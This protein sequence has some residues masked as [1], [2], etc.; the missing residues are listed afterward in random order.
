MAGQPGIDATLDLNGIGSVQASQIDSSFSNVGN[1]IDSSLEAQYSSSIADIGI[2]SADIPSSYS[3][4]TK[5]VD[6]TT[7]TEAT[8]ESSFQATAST[9]EVNREVSTFIEPENAYILSIIAEL[10]INDDMAEEMRLEMIMNLLANNFSYEADSAGEAWNTV[11]NTLATRSGDCED[12]SN[13]AASLLVAAGFPAEDVNV[14]VNIS[15]NVGEQGHVVVG[16]MINDQEV[17]LDF[18]QMINAADGN[19]I[20]VNES[21]YSNNQLN[22]QQYDFSY[23]VNGVEKLSAS[24]SN[25]IVMEDVNNAESFYTA[26]TTILGAARAELINK[27]NSL[28]PA[29]ASPGEIFILLQ[30]AQ[31]YLDATTEGANSTGARAELISS[32]NNLNPETA[33]PGEIFKLQQVAQEYLTETSTEVNH[34]ILSDAF[35]EGGAR[36]LMQTAFEISVDKVIAVAPPGSSKYQQMLYSMANTIEALFETLLA[37]SDFMAQSSETLEDPGSLFDLQQEIQHVKDTISTLTAVGSLG[38]DVINT[39]LTQFVRDLNG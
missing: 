10:G 37:M 20:E 13:F 31:E 27:I 8:Y 34:A 22:K 7:A 15:E 6:S 19:Y 1:E 28:N 36:A 24:I 23:S 33:S 32:I 17:K 4:T 18:A 38:T 26:G 5:Q 16:L 2:S 21:F 14:Y 35:A 9:G 30:A 3:S 25:N 39:H 11:E 12:L 29:T